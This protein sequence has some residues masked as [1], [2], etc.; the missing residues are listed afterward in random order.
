ML[1]FILGLI[2]GSFFAF[3]VFCL[4]ACRRI[5]PTPI[6]AEE[7]MPCIRNISQKT[8]RDWF[9]KLDEEVTEFKAEV[10]KSAD[11][12]MEAKDFEAPMQGMVLRIAEEGCDVATV[13]RSF[14][15]ALNIKAIDF[16]KAQKR[17]NQH[18]AERG[19]L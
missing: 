6:E 17:V 4:F 7:P 5:V 15:Y 10:L 19:R 2:V 13:I 14:G 9:A 12:D 3:I 16:Q 18:N 1:P 11:L 8:I